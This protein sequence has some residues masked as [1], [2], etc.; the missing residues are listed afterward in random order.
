MYEALF[1]FLSSQISKKKI[2]PDLRLVRVK[3]HTPIYI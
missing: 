3:I 2:A 1:F